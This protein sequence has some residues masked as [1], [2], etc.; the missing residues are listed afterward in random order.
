MPDERRPDDL[1]PMGWL[2]NPDAVPGMTFLQHHKRL[3]RSYL[4]AATSMQYGGIVLPYH[5]DVLSVARNFLAED[6]PDITVIMAQTACEIATEEVISQLLRYH[7]FTIAIEAWM[8]KRIERTST[9]RSESLYDL[10]CALSGDDLKKSETLLWD[11]Y[12][13]SV[14]IRNNIVHKGGHASG[15]QAKTS[16]EIAESLIHHFEAVLARVTAK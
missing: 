4:T 6:R 9:L 15:V 12:V 11:G 2:P 14:G 5:Y 8:R 3:V 10:Y 1:P 16:C 7:N 13:A